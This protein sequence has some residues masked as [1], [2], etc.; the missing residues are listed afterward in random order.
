MDTRTMPDRGL[1]DSLAVKETDVQI[2]PEIA[3]RHVA[4]TKA[5]KTW[6]HE[7]IARLER[8]YERLITCRIMV[9]QAERSH[10]KGNHYR[11]RIE[12][13]VPGSPPLVVRRNPAARDTNEELQQAIGEAFDR[14]RAMLVDFAQRQRG[15]IKLHELPDHGHVIEMAGDHGFIRGADQREIYF[16]RNS[17]AR[18]S[19][20]DL[21]VGSEVRFVESRGDEG[22]QAST[23]LPIGKHHIV[24]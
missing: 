5:L 2:E 9:E 1:I 14:A 13:S 23:V 20:E 24:G 17:V 22:P 19:F 16:H 15:D 10:K 7:G 11:V 6:I 18:G 12:M 8:V 3:L 21:D 4:P